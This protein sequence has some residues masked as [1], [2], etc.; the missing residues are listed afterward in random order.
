MGQKSSA[1]YDFSTNFI[2]LTGISTKMPKK[3][4]VVDDEFT[5]RELVELVL[6]P[7]YE[8]IKAENGE[9]ALK[10]VKDKPDLIILDIM[11]PK[12]DGYHVCQM[13]RSDPETK[14]IPIIMLTA[15]H[16]IED[17][18]E[19]IRSDV[20]EYI[21]KPFEPEHLKKRVDEYTS[22]HRPTKR[23]LLQVG[24]SLHYIK[25]KE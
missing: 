10:L 18:K 16:G 2:Y 14:D 17:L 23:R 4:L 15:K 7:D 8:V 9:E 12:I 1:G 22:G 5:I 6:T 21:T 25:E 13:V 19:A 11:M 24:K 3:I 20:D